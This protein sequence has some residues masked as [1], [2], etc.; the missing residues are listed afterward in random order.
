MDEGVAARLA[1][2]QQES[3]R[4]GR[5][6]HIFDT[7]YYFYLSHY[8]VQYYQLSRFVAWRLPSGGIF[9]ALQGVLRSLTIEKMVR[10]LILWVMDS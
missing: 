7:T 4:S 3:Q 6:Y 10:H 9:E 2:P 5:V 1:G 8:S